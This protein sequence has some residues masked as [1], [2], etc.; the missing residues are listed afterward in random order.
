MSDL[1]DSSEN[2]SSASSTS[3]QWPSQSSHGSK[4]SGNDELQTLRYQEILNRAIDIDSVADDNVHRG[5]NTDIVSDAI[6]KAAQL[7]HS[8]EILLLVTGAGFSADS[9]L[10]TYADVADIDAYRERGWRYRDLCRPFVVNN[11]IDIMDHNE[12]YYRDKN[13]RT[14]TLMLWIME[15][16]RLVLS[17]LSNNMR[18]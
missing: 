2:G 14:L 17:F 18:K 4:C 7:L 3:T 11:S 8:A 16:M 13:D 12:E 6:R 9:G 10:A 5:D 1:L 15:W